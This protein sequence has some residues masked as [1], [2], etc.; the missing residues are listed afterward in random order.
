MGVELMN[1]LHDDLGVQLTMEDFSM[2]T[3]V[4]ELTITVGQM[5]LAQYGDDVPGGATAAGELAAMATSRPRPPG[6]L[7]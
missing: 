1:A 4:K 5:L 7:S 6:L 3:T 2:E